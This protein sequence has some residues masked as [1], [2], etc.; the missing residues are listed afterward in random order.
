MKIARECAGV[1][2]IHGKVYVIGGYDSSGQPMVFF[3]RYGIRTDEWDFFP[4]LPIATAQNTAVNIN[5]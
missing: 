3:E 4:N 2:E 5:N 1:V